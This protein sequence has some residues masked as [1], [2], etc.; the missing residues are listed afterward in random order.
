MSATTLEWLVILVFFLLLVGAMAGEIG[1]LVVKKWTTVGRAAALVITSN[2]VSM[3]I[4]SFLVGAIMLILFMM[5]MGPAGRGSD[6]PESAYVIGIALA[7]IIPPVLLLAAKRIM[8]AILKIRSGSSAW[9]Y[10]A[11]STVLTFLITLV[12]TAVFIYVISRK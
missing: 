11:V 7:L 3:T 9:V 4:G 8:L 5:V 10:S 1:W 12:P 2:I 6:A